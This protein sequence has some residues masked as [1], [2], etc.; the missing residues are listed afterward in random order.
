MWLYVLKS[1]SE[2][3]S[4]FREWKVMVE[5]STGRKLKVWRSDNGGKYTSGKF[6]EFLVSEGIRHEQSPTKWGG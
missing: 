4:K 1:K 3:F 2:V 5:R 6:A